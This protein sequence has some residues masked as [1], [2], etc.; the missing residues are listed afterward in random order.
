MSASAVAKRPSITAEDPPPTEGRPAVR[1]KWRATGTKRWSV[2]RE[3]IGFKLTVA[4]VAIAV[5]FGFYERD[6]EYISPDT[7]LGYWLGIV[8]ASMMVLLLF[9][10]YRKRQG[11]GRGFLSIPAWFRI[12]MLLGTFGPLLV[13]FHSNFHMR[14]ANSAVAL[15]TMLIVAFSGLVGRYLYRMIHAG[16]DSRKS[17]SQALAEELA[18]IRSQYGGAGQLP[19]SL[20]DE[21]DAFGSTIMERQGSGV[22]ES[23]AFGATR[24]ARAFWMRR[25]VGRHIFDLVK[26]KGAAESWAWPER[27]ARARELTQ[28]V[29][30]YFDA[31]LKVARQRFIERLFSLW[32]MFH[33]PL[34]FVMVLT[35]VVHIWAVHRY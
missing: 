21:L 26:A 20:F 14:A 10:S 5:I 15:V 28:V 25:A 33:L 18:A 6:E 13:V 22:L 30:A 27:R 7:G 23:L 34:Y 12:H 24:I 2:P 31:T 1:Q 35:A 16:L 4:V 8:G 9:Y 19:Q 3:G 11:A 29:D 17:A 32:H